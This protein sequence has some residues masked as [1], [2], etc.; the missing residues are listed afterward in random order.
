MSVSSSARGTLATSY[1]INYRRLTEAMS[2][3]F[4]VMMTP[5]SLWRGYWTCCKTLIQLCPTLSQVSI[6][7]RQLHAMY[8][9]SIRCIRPSACYICQLPARNMC[10]A[11]P[12]LCHKLCLMMCGSC[13]VWLK[14]MIKLENIESTRF[15]WHE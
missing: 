3:C 1:V 6:L 9:C 11:D 2:G 12:F 10:W 7:P 13:S 8:T 14:M 15:A 5:C 4:M